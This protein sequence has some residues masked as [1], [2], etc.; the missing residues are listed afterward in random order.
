MKRFLFGFTM[1]ALFVIGGLFL[2][3]FAAVA[4]PV[5]VAQ[6]LSGDAAAFP[7]FVGAAGL[8]LN[9]SNL[10]DLFRGFKASFN[11]GFRTPESHWAKVA[12]LVPS[13]KSEEKYAW[14]GQYPRIR[15]WIGDRHIKSMEAHDYT[16]KN[17]KFESSI[18]VPR[19]N[20]D[21]DSYGVFSPMFQEMGYAAQTHPEELVFYLLAGGF[22]ELCYD[23]QYFFDPDHPVGEGTVSNF[24]A[25]ASTPWFLLD[26]RRPLKPLI[27]QRR[28]DYDLKA[29]N[30]MDDEGV[31][32]RDEYRYGVDA[33]V[34]AGFGFWQQAFG[35]KAA[36][37]AANY[38]AARVAMSSLKSDEARP[39]G[40]SP[41]LLVV[42]PALEGAAKDI[43][44]SDRLAN[45]A[46]NKWRNTA[47]LLV[48]P[49]LA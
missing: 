16:V 45:G 22:T 21:D 48:V 46:A 6:M 49:W 18:A 24:Q 13:T 38:E 3:G 2:A 25:G 14:L 44:V 43:L 19:D 26:V 47:E 10:T 23:G 33:R 42:P 12:T 4:A 7:P 9:Q 28:R 35:S 29:M 8:I 11:T 41:S 39:L 32:M 20:I 40:I 37:T 27:F 5:T 1:L 36:L 34:N 30:K 17:K 31:F 15:E